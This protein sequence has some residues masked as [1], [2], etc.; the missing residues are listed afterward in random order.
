MTQIKK[1]ELLTISEVATKEKVTTNTVYVWIKSG[2]ISP[3][4][5]IGNTVFIGKKYK[6]DRKVK[7][8]LAL[9]HA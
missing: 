2:Q 6:I 8:N 1:L 9:N 4:S 7:N 3:L 5:Q